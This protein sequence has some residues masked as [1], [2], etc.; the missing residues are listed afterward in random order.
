MDKSPTPKVVTPRAKTVADDDD[1]HAEEK[2]GVAASSREKP[3][4]S[5]VDEDDEDDEED[6]EEHDDAEDDDDESENGPPSGAKK[7][8][9]DV[10]G[11]AKRDTSNPREDDDGGSKNRRGR[12]VIGIVLCVGVVLFARASLADHYVVPTGSMVPTVGVNDRVVVAK[13]AY[14]LRI[15][16]TDSWLIRWGAGPKRGDVVVLESPEGGT[17]LLKRVIGLPGDT[18]TVNAGT[19]AVNG[20]EMP[21]TPQD[22]PEGELFIED[23]DGK[24]HVVSLQAGGGPDWGPKQLPEGKYLVMGD[25]RGNSRDGRFFGLVDGNAILGH[26]VRIYY[27]GA[28]PS[29]FGGFEWKDL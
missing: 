1:E 18:V 28:S 16:L 17:I 11:T 4:Q 25:N 27:R 19:I 15:P 22:R 10:G 13:A 14:G 3:G 8:V 6:A 9:L 21:V 12:D 26:A 20:R 2:E 23:L 7:K 24:K 29:F 5:P